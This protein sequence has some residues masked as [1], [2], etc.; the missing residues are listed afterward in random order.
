MNLFGNPRNKEIKNFRPQKM[1]QALLPLKLFQMHS[2]GAEM[3]MNFRRQHINSAMS[4]S[5]FVHLC[6]LYRNSAKI[7]FGYI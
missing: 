7:Q 5:T 6:W 1:T 3:F 4:I 2:L